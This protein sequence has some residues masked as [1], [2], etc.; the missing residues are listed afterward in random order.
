MSQAYKS[1]FNIY[2]VNADLQY[3][4]DLVVNNSLDISN[5]TVYGPTANWSELQNELD[6]KLSRS[7]GNITGNVTCN[8]GVTIDGVDLSEIDTTYLRLDGTSQMNGNLDMDGNF[9][10]NC[11]QFFGS[12]INALVG[13]NTNFINDLS[14][15]GVTIE[16]VNIN[17]STILA[18]TIN[19]ITTNA[20]VTVETVLIKDGLVDGV[21]VSTLPG[22]ITT[23]QTTADNALPKSGGNMTGNI[24]LNAGLTVDGVDISAIPLTF[25]PLAGGTMTGDIVMGSKFITN[26]GTITCGSVIPTSSLTYNLGSGGNIW[27]NLYLYTSYIGYIY[28][29]NFVQGTRTTT[30]AS[31]PTFSWLDNSGNGM[32]SSGTNNVDFST[33][34]TNRLNI[35][36]TAITSTIPFVATTLKTTTNGN[37]S[38]PSL[39]LNDTD[40][41]FWSGTNQINASTGGTNRLQLDSTALALT[42][43]VRTSSSSVSNVAYGLSGDDNTGLHFSAADTLDFV[44]GGS[45]RMYVHST[46]VYADVPI[47]CDSGTV[48]APALTFSQD[49]TTGVFNTTNEIHFTC[50]GTEVCKLNG[51]TLTF[52]ASLGQKIVLWTSGGI[53]YG[54][55]IS[56]NTLE[57]RSANTASFHKFYTGANLRL[58][59]SNTEVS[60]D[61]PFVSSHFYLDSDQD[62]GLVLGGSN[63]IWLLAGSNLVFEADATNIVYYNHCLPGTNNT[64]TLGNTSLRWKEVWCNAGAFNTSDMRLKEDIQPLLLGLDFVKDLN[65]V[66]FKWKNKEGEKEHTRSHVGMIAQ[67]IERSI[68]EHGYDLNKCDIVSNEYLVDPIG[69]DCYALRYDA[70]TPC[71]IKAIQELSNKVDKL[72]KKLKST[73]KFVNFKRKSPRIVIRKNKSTKAINNNPRQE[74]YDI[75]VDATCEKSSTS[76]RM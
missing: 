27:N 36:T 40:T 15:S 44:T 47:V 61:V 16:N 74:Y 43:P 6:L 23:A 57:Y 42:V 56:A 37:Q 30:N 34:S 24:T 18:D 7:G 10:I 13:V 17:S 21:D 68:Y 25:L 12:T 73:R 54:F 41:G 11:S 55:N 35:S 63:L 51:S 58:T 45:I 72:E 14:G 59:V 5:A 70:I 8:P 9:I 65:P 69:T 71:L 53:Y 62:T 46:G 49:L 20:G 33:N 50:G 31:S 66:T 26:A 29:D 38:S 1:L 19:E 3:V 64:Y 22:L 76:E 32:Y 28:S 75:S 2:E 48:S 67:E 39:L 52:P 4:D 60:S